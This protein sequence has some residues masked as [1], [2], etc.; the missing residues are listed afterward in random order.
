MVKKTRKE[1]GEL[2]HLNDKANTIPDSTESAVWLPTW[3]RVA[4]KR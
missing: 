2:L 1:M 4:E 3:F